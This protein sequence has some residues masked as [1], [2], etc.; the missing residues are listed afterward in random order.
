MSNDAAVLRVLEAVMRMR[1]AVAPEGEAVTLEEILPE[2]DLML[3]ITSDI[4]VRGDLVQLLQ[5][6]ISANEDR[7]AMSGPM[8]RTRYLYL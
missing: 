6:V 8:E 5:R 4:P 1:G 3:K 2:V 7:F